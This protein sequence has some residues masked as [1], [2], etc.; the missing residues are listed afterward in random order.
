MERSVTDDYDL[1]HRITPE[2]EPVHLALLNWAEWSRDRIRR[3]HC[4]SIEH[5]YNAGNVFQDDRGPATMFDS[6]AALEVHRHVCGVPARERWILHLWYIHS[7]PEGYVRRKIG[8]RRG[9]MHEELNRARRM[10]AN[11]MGKGIIAPDS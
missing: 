9:E 5:K 4:R 3:G 11:R 2:C 8:I 6:L 1:I 7:A 10:L